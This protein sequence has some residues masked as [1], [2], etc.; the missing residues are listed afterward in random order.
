MAMRPGDCHL[1]TALANQ[2]KMPKYMVWI[3]FEAYYWLRRVAE[4]LTSGQCPVGYDPGCYSS[5][6][7]SV[8]LGSILKSE[9]YQKVT[10]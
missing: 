2:Y 4:A 8:H 5:A 6:T 10:K 3:H 9:T 1:G 7:V